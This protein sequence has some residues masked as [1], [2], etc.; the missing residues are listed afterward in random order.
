MANTCAVKAKLDSPSGPKLRKK[1][2]SEPTMTL[3]TKAAT[4]DI[5]EI[6][7]APLQESGAHEEAESADEDDY[8]TDGD[9]TTD[10][11]SAG[12][13]RV[14][15]AGQHEE[16]EASDARS[17]SEWSDFAT[18]KHVPSIEGGD[19]VEADERHTCRLDR[20]ERYS[21]E[22]SGQLAKDTPPPE[23]DQ[24]NESAVEGESS[25]RTRTIY[26]PPP[27]DYDPPTR[28]FRD[29]VE[30]ANSRLPF[31]TP[32]TERTEC[33]LDVD[34]ERRGQHKTP[35]K[36]ELSSATVGKPM[37]LEPPSS[38]LREIDYDVDD[39]GDD[40]GSTVSRVPEPPA[41]KAATPARPAAV[42]VKGPM[43]HDKQCNPVDRAIRRDILDRVS[44]P[45]ASYTGFHDHRG[46]R[47]GRGAEIRRF[48]KALSK[49]NRSGADKAAAP[50]E[51][52]VLR[53]PHM[54]AGYT[55]KREL[56]AG[57]F[58]PVYLVENSAADKETHEGAVA[59]M[60]QG[61]FAV[62]RRS[63][64]EALKMESPPTPWEFYM[65]R[66]AHTRLGPQHRAA[67]SLSYAHEMHIYQDEAF[68]F[69]PYHAHGTLLDLV[70]LFRTEPSGVMDELLAMFFTVE[71]LR[72]V[73]ALHSKGVMHGD[74][75]P[76]NCL[77]RLD[78][79]ASEQQPL[80]A[81]WRADGGGGWSSRGL[82]LIDFGRAIDFKAF[83][84][85]VEFIADW[86]TNAQDCAEMREG[87]PWTWQIDYHGLAGTV[88]CLL[89][90]KYMETARCDEG[91]LGRTGRRYR[92]RESLKRYWQTGLWADMLELLLNPGSCLAADGAARMPVVGPLRAVRE[93][94]E[95]WLEANCE[96]GVGLRSLVGKLEAHAKNRR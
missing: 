31:M 13:T 17:A 58:A 54:E 43:V 26:V 37:T 7:N 83:E 12:T 30:V 70:N 77:L 16:D 79:A 52:V 86:K 50:P 32:I 90:G 8:E 9:Y 10:A 59:V 34:A 20:A 24:G 84:P 2:T 29:P 46:E 19:E 22:Q 45:L 66:V 65:M 89:F 48:A 41:P 23:D 95:D 35:C 38:P 82:V 40:G 61:A 21:S 62:S 68:L 74:I 39:D 63:K 73:E 36:G 49:A 1:N 93:R 47:Y 67:A 14:V 81:Q 42:A 5:Y 64:L 80:A 28:P 88:H 96:R 56:G 25:P 18:H 87:R 4:D 3:H 91:G 69:L 94:M 6:F 57:A 92:I 53:F 72:T 15:D 33:S 44:P 27:P 85:D 71:L 51:A 60:G 78:P 55:L 75:K 11:E 76:D